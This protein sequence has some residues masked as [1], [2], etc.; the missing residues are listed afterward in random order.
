M[1]THGLEVGLKQLVLKLIFF[2]LTFF[3]CRN[4]IAQENSH[5]AKELSTRNWN[6][7][8]AAIALIN[9]NVDSLG[10]IPE[11]RTGFADL[12]HRE[13]QY[14]RD[15]SS[16][17]MEKL[18][19]ETEGDA[20]F[21]VVRMDLKEALPDLLD[22]SGNSPVFRKYIIKNILTHNCNENPILDSLLDR[23]GTHGEFY[24]VEMDGYFAIACAILDS[25]KNACPKLK[26]K[27]QEY[28]K[29][30]LF[31]I[32][33][34]VRMAS[35]KCACHTLQDTIISNRL[36]QIAK[37]DPYKRTKNGKTVFPVRDAAQNTLSIQKK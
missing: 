25:T 28:I 26:S 30:N 23:F 9:Q 8:S 15:S 13:T 1:G 4:L 2:S 5:I 24:E 12:F 6:V 33:P 22:W 19:Q 34:F 21:L 7:A 29:S 35:A 14:L 32:D 36:N 11:V 27:V 31:S 37:S 18:T 17:S 20:A 16:N 10:Q 3:F